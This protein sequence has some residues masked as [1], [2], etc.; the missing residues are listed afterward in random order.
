MLMIRTAVA[1]QGR[2]AA[3]SMKSPSAHLPS[4]RGRRRRFTPRHPPSPSPGA[5]A[6]WPPASSS[7]GAAPRPERATCRPPW[8]QRA[9]RLLEIKFVDFEPGA[10]QGG[11]RAQR[12]VGDGEH[13]RAAAAA[14]AGDRIH[15]G[16]KLIAKATSRVEAKPIS[17]GRHCRQDCSPTFE[18]RRRER[19]ADRRRN[20]CR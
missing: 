16:L 9:E 14:G 3:S 7:G 20:S 4:T 2:R 5:H 15:Q 19:H 11:E 13:R 10:R 18:L 1:F 17:S 6:S 12:T 8:S